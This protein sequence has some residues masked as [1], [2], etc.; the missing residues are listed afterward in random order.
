MAYRSKYICDKR[1]RRTL[2]TS[3][4]TTSQKQE[5]TTTPQLK[6]RAIRD[7]VL[8]KAI[9]AKDNPYPNSTTIKNAPVEAKIL[10]CSFTTVDRK[11]FSNDPLERPNLFS[12]DNINSPIWP[13]DTQ[14]E[15]SKVSPTEE[16]IFG[17]QTTA[18]ALHNKIQSMR[19]SDET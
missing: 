13:D 16:E 8:I 19:K 14:H 2:L 12:S 9:T 1:Q 3:F 7:L 17:L 11:I 10:I 15:L 6:E 18:S 5:Q 4:C